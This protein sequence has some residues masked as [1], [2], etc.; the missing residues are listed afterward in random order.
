VYRFT[1][2]EGEVEIL[3]QKQNIRTTTLGS[4]SRD[5][6]KEANFATCNSVVSC[7]VI[8]NLVEYIF[9]FSLHIAIVHT[10]ILGDFESF[11]DRIVWWRVSTCVPA[12]ESQVTLRPSPDILDGKN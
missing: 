2:G 7:A 10:L 5:D 8:S 3:N 6:T 12:P 1:S 11:T 9:P 4:T